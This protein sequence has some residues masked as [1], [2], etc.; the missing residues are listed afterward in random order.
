[1]EIFTN[2][3]LLWIIILVLVILNITSLTT[4]WLKVWDTKVPEFRET[5][6]PLAKDHFLNRRLN[7][8][9]EQQAQFDE[10]LLKHRTALDEKVNEIHSLRKELMSMMRNKDFSPES[11]EIFL[12]IGQKQSELE[13]I[14]FIHFKEVMAICNDEQK[15]VFMETMIRAVGPNRRM[16]NQ[17]EGNG[18]RRNARPGRGK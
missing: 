3:K 18:F 13:L 12:N 5:R 11:E 16:G 15:Q 4:I 17:N 8:T 14:N 2:K 1:M 10:L 9:S 7:F 6:R